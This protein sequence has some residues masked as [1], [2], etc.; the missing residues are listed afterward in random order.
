[1][2]NRTTSTAAAK[3]SL[4]YALG[5]CMGA[6]LLAFTL[7]AVA[8]IDLAWADEPAVALAED[9]NQYTAEMQGG[10]QLGHT[11]TVVLSGPKSSD[12][13]LAES[14][15]E[16]FMM[17]RGGSSKT[18]KIPLDPQYLYTDIRCSVSNTTSEAEVINAVGPVD[19]AEST[20]TISSSDSSG[21]VVPGCTLTVSFDAFE[22]ATSAESSTVAE[23]CS[24]GWYVAGTDT[25]V[26]SGMSFTVPSG[27][28]YLG[29][30]FE[31]RINANNSNFVIGSQ[32]GKSAEVTKPKPKP[33]PADDDPSDPTDPADTPVAPP[34]SP[35]TGPTAGPSTGPS[36]SSTPS[37]PDTGVVTATSSTTSDPINKPKPEKKKKEEE[38]N[39]AAAATGTKD[40]GKTISETSDSAVVDEASE[41]GDSSEDSDG[42]PWLLIGIGALVFVGAALGGFAFW[43]RRQSGFGLADAGVAV[44]ATAAAAGAA[45]GV[46]ALAAAAGAAAFETALAAEVS[47]LALIMEHDPKR[48]LIFHE[49]SEFARELASLIQS[50]PFMRCKELP[51]SE[52]DD[53][54]DAITE[55]HPDL[56]V[57][58]LKGGESSAALLPKF[59]QA[60]QSFENAKGGIL[61]SAPRTE[62]LTHELSELRASGDI[63]EF[64]FDSI[65][66][67]DA[68]VRFSVPLFRDTIATNNPLTLLGGVATVLG[69]PFVADALN[70]YANGRDIREV[71][72]HGK[73]NTADK[74]SIIGDIASCLGINSVWAVA[75]FI[76]AAAEVSEDRSDRTESE[77]MD[78]ESFAK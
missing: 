59:E 9:L 61:V 21:A 10:V 41:K 28:A 30:S 24:Y 27:S 20:V 22:G 36:G 29:K 70:F 72:D 48:V 4:V 55:F 62:A 63:L 7:H 68:L 19:L 74:V 14:S 39:E 1:M 40:P 46:D 54:A 15:I 35:T 11:V 52:F 8:A 45:V 53:S 44:G 51:L 33:T 73:I 37:G 67:Q 56:V 58:P 43:R 3:R 69:I 57:L 60:R 77:A 65:D 16:W 76:H 13:V 64:A 47:R 18:F 31:W 6:L 26:G 42:A 49:G 32:Q 5:A 75:S 66:V 71:L 17:D 38:K 78:S 25:K 2:L 34:S 50:K 23:A 12:E